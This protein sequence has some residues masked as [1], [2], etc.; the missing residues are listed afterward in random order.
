MAID[1]VDLSKPAE[2][3]AGYAL[4]DVALPPPMASMT[5]VATLVGLCVPQMGMHSLPAT[6]LEGTGPFRGT[7]V[8]GYNKGQN[9]FIEPMISRA[10]LMEKASFD[11]LSPSIPGMKGSYPHSFRAEYDSAAAAYR[12][13]FSGFSSGG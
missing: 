4:P 9:V 6:E 12:F 1:C 5:G 8:I 7:M 2:L 11:L 10:M 13:V 3:S